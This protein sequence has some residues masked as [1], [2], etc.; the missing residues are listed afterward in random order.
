MIIVVR[1]G[2]SGQIGDDRERAHCPPELAGRRFDKH[3]VI[4]AG[5]Q[6]GPV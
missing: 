1:Y 3:G 4:W 6:A 2:C 5:D